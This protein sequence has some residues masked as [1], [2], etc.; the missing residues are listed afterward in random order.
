MEYE[1]WEEL[2]DSVAEAVGVEDGGEAELARRIARRQMGRMG[3]LRDP[4][5][6]R[7]RHPF[8]LL[9]GVAEEAALGTEFWCAHYDRCFPS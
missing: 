7:V 8:T 1:G 4:V 5:R 3:E 9:R 6:R 2:V